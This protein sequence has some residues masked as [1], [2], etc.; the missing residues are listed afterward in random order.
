M[1]VGGRTTHRYRDVTDY[2]KAGA[3]VEDAKAED[4]IQFKANNNFTLDCSIGG[5]DFR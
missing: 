1:D 2:N 3:V 5:L 4:R